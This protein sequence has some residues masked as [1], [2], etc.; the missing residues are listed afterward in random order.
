MI[1]PKTEKLLIHKEVNDNL[2]SILKRKVFSNGYIFYG[3]EGIGKKQTAIKFIKEIFYQY[4]SNPN[5]EEKLLDNNHPDFLLIEPTF[6]FKGK[7]INRL[8][9]EPTKNQK[10]SIRI[11]QIR[12]IRNFLGQKSIE[13]G[14]KIVLI[15]NADLLNEAASNCLLKTLEEPAN[16]LFIL[17]TSKLNALLD[18]I[19]SRCQL[20][21]F[22]S[23]SYKQL[24]I[25]IRNNSNTSIINIDEQLDIKD[26]INTANGSPGK[27]MNNIKY[28]NELPPEIKSNLD[29]PLSDNLEILK[30]SKIISEELEI[31]Q[32]IFLI[33]FVQNKCW[34]K[35][36]NKNIVKKLEDLK[37]YLRGFVQPRLAWEVTLLKI[38]IED[39]KN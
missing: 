25:F 38:S 26:L 15:V 12:N 28:W 8:E 11:E 5:I 32:Q 36:R 18:T 39:L 19:I 13:S 16:G 34:K 30:I 2:E 9:T 29:F 10:E 23:F 4:T 27:I 6:F 14:K 24:E 3:P 31:Y 20:I 33:N 7:F 1:D 37:V 22:K 35:T 21:R 17:L